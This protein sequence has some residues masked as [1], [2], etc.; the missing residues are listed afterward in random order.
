MENLLEKT[1]RALSAYTDKRLAV[2]VSG[3]RDSICLLHA[4]TNCG[5]VKKSNLIAVHVNHGLRETAVRDEQFVRDFCEKNGIAFR[6]FGV[7]VKTYAERNGLTVEQAAREL[8]YDI[9]YTLV[10]SGAADVVLTAH[11][12]LDNAESVLMHIFRGSGIDGLRPMRAAATLRPFLDVYPKELDEYAANNGLRYVT[13]ETNF[14]DAP[15]RNFIRLKVLPLI[16]QRYGGAV[17][18]INAL[19]RESAET[20][21]CLDALLCGDHI[22]YDG[23]AA[24]I[25]DEALNSALAARYVRRALVN[26]TLTDITRA[27]IE[28]VVALRSARTGAAIELSHGIVAA[29]EYGAVAL[30]IPRTKC[31]AEIAAHCGANYID[32]LAVD[33]LPCDAPIDKVRGGEADLDKIEGATLRFR[34]DGDVFKP[35]GGGRKKLKQYFIDKKIASRLRDRIPLLCRGSEVLA[36]VGVEI[37]D[38]VKLTDGT[39]RKAVVKL[40]R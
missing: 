38:D 26:F 23:G 31:G 36:V 29:R 3:G 22:T 6:A 12:A 14:D 33:I 35:F 32:G 5:A 39:A 30:Y 13:D 27:Q 40:R 37:S 21:D 25:C 10:K 17:R 9:F 18:A 4:A 20:C 11:H 19:S 7:D 8:R 16:E 15:D 1:A 34:R 28:S 24:V 2:G